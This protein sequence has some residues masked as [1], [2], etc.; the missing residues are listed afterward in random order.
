MG[1]YIQYDGGKRKK[2]SKEK[3]EDEKGHRRPN[4]TKMQTGRIK[5]Q[6]SLF[7]RGKSTNYMTMNATH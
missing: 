3:E 1:K 6:M 4:V 2:K 5:T 7:A